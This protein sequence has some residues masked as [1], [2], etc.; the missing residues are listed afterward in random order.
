LHILRNRIEKGSKE[1]RVLYISQYF[2]PEVGATQSRS[3]EMAKHLVEQG[4][5]VTVIT[6]MPN[7]PK[8][9]IQAGYRGKF[10][11]KEELDGIKILRV[12]VYTS[13][14]K[15]FISRI[16]FYTTFMVTSFIAGLFSRGRYNII[17]ATSPPFFVGAS[18]LLLSFLKRCKFIFEARDLWP[19][20][21][22]VL[23]E[24]NNS[25]LIFASK[26][27]EKIYYKYASAIIA[28]TDGIKQRLISNDV[29]EKKIFVITNGSNSEIFKPYPK[30]KLKELLLE[31][32]F[33]VGYAGIFGIAQGME[34]LCDLIQSMKEDQKIKFLFIGEGPKKKRVIELKNTMQLKNLIILDEI[35]KDKIAQYIS[36]FDIA[37]V[38]LKKCFLFE[39]AVPTKMFDCMACEKPIVLAI[40]GEAKEIIEKSRS[41]IAVE[42]ENIREMRE[43][44]LKFYQSEKL[45]QEMGKK[46]RKY[47]K[48]EKERAA[49]ASDLEQVMQKIV[50]TK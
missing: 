39:G 46:A 25:I 10:F 20:S 8:G 6:E 28:V 12:W 5:S 16:L 2:P 33:I 21:A 36:C 43:A 44:I 40:Q 11:L 1:L 49:L 13:P 24:L 34:I 17:F 47:V 22:I 4:H 32:C 35:P 50:F 14:H 27:V 3:Y 48:K 23:N 42:P 41:G 38:P 9:I 29:P 26:V 45:V 18:G 37:L 30:N 7:H 31:E 15:T 19:E